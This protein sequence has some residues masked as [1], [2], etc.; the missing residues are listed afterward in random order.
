MAYPIAF[1]I[2][3]AGGFTTNGTTSI[4][5]I[6]YSSIKKTPIIFGSKEEMDILN[7]ILV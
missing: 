2:E 7:D 1:I 6:P 4:L 3:K 5:D